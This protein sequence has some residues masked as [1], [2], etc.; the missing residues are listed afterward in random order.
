LK[1]GDNKDVSRPEIANGLDKVDI[2]NP[3]EDDTA[4]PAAVKSSVKVMLEV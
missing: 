3:L 2:Y 4:T 1:Y